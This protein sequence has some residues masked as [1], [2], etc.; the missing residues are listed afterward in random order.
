MLL[1]GRHVSADEGLALGFVNAV[2]P[3]GAALTA[4]KQWA[5]QMLECSPMSLNA[6]KE[7]AGHVGHDWRA[8]M[9]LSGNLPAV[10]ALIA[11]EDMTEG[12]RAFLE[13]RKPVWRSR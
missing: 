10:K 7:I 2:V 9:D 11:S 3:E 8:A 13:R 4:A 6:I 1:T 12:P 5:T